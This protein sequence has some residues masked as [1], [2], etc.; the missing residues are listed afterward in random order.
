MQ[1]ILGWSECKA[2]EDELQVRLAR[3]LSNNNAN[4]GA[5]NGGKKK[6][7]ATRAGKKKGTRSGKK[8]GTRGGKKKGTRS[9]KKKGTRK[10]GTPCPRQVKQIDDDCLVAALKYQAAA[11]AFIVN[12]ERQSKR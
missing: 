5:V 1:R 8:K 12:L 2:V 3:G 4:Q 6:K 10:A 7:K 11:S 9:G